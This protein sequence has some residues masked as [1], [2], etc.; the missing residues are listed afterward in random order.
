MIVIDYPQ[1]LARPRTR[2]TSPRAGEADLIVAK[3][4]NGPTDTIT[5]A[6]Q[7]HYSRFTD[8]APGM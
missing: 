7:G 3:H 5:V 6:F 2:R 8:M 4:R 1:P